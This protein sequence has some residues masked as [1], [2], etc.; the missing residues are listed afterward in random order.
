MRSKADVGPDQHR[1]AG[2]EWSRGCSSPP[3]SRLSS[4][5]SRKW[6]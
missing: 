6:N 1:A 2:T 4:Q 3:R 5:P